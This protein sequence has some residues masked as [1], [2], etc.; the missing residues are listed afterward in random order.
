MQSVNDKRLLASKVSYSLMCLHKY[1]QWAKNQACENSSFL[2]IDYQLLKIVFLFRLFFL[3][4]NVTIF[5]ISKCMNSGHKP[6][7]RDSSSL[8]A[9]FSNTYCEAVRPLSYW[10]NLTLAAT[11][12]TVIHS[13]CR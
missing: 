3:S 1:T 2:K 7:S 4:N 5:I 6:A 13:G 9:N 10:S 11:P 12:R 8:L